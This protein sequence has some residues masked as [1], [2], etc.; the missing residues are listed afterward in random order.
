[1]DHRPKQRLARAGRHWAAARALRR[2]VLARLGLQGKLILG[3]GFIL[4]IAMT[5][6]SAVFVL[7]G[8]D[9][10]SDIL[11]EQA[12]QISQTLAMAAEAPYLDH[13]I[14]QLTRLGKDLLKGRNIVLVAFY[15]S[16][17]KTLTSACRDPDFPLHNG[18]GDL[19]T[20]HLMQVRP[21]TSPTMGD[22]LQVTAPVF[23]IIRE[24]GHADTPVR[25]LGYLTVGIAQNAER[26]QMQRA[27]LLGVAVGCAIFLLSLPV[28]S[29]V[30]HRIMLPIRELVKATNRIASGCYDTQVATDRP[31]EIGKLARAFN[32]MVKRITQHQLDLR[33]AN[34]S[35]AEA[36]HDLEEKVRLRTGELEAINHRLS[37]E[38]AEK[39]DFLRA[40]SHDLNAPLRNIGGMATMLLLKCR[41]KFD[42]DVVHRLERI[43]KNVEVET[44]LISE[45]LELS[46]IRTRRHKL[47]LVDVGQL[48]SELGGLFEDDLK[49]KGIEL[50]LDTK[51]PAILAE[52]ARLR[53]VFQN[54]VDNAIKYMPEREPR[55]IHIGHAKTPGGTEFYVRDTG[56]GIDPEDLTKIFYVFRRGKNS[57]ELGVAGKGVGLASVKSIVQTHGGRI[58][59][60]SRLGEGSTF[61]FTINAKQD[62]DETE[63]PAPLAA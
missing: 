56:M 3:F 58:W 14:D 8:R 55:E 7:R 40:V 20:Q 38:I 28:A 19:G 24:P 11:G 15:D 29:A 10:L 5:T 23:A 13:D 57:A 61:F 53:Q 43:R 33:I 30:V 60:Q 52:K 63:E 42:E 31:D 62:T 25:L 44:D 59:A 37:G 51:L 48:A 2:E 45:L 32:E 18:P 50:I 6:A 4:M 49:Q 36:N 39:E 12:R 21:R 47:E 41:E 27:S 46:R 34:E 17:G 22:F 26:E 16:G 35:L 54:L 9:T 1:M